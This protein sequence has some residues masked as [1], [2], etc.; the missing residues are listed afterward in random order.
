MPALRRALATELRRL[1][2]HAS[3]SGDVVA[4]RLGWSASKVSRIETDRTGI[5]R[6]DLDRLLDLYGADEATRHQLEALADE[7]GARGWW[8]PLATTFPAAY[9]TYIGLEDSAATLQSWSPELIHG[10]LQTEDYARA[11][12]Q[13]AFGSPPRV[14]PGEIERRV[15]ARLWRQ[16]L[17]WRRDAREY[18]FILDEAALRHRLGSVET[19]HAQLTH[20]RRISGLPNVTIRVLPFTAAYPIGPCGFAILGFAPAHGALLGDVVYVEHLTGQSLFENEAETYEYRLAFEQLQAGALNA[21]T[22]MQLV[23][24]VARD[25]WA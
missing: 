21:A 13:S 8:T 14:P 2:E 11:T 16:R 19:M 1:R 23:G 25:V 3:M 22:S 10:L 15:E 4:A 7:Q 24:A 20:L 6:R 9:V 17:L 12:M 5:K 18:V